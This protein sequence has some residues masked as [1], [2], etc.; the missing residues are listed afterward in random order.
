M[1]T[2]T[3]SASDLR[4]SLLIGF[5]PAITSRPDL[6]AEVTENLARQFN[7]AGVSGLRIV[8][9]AKATNLEAEH[10]NALLRAMAA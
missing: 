7:E 5:Q 8:N 6:L 2:R 3:I 4:Q 1:S 10:L 9:A